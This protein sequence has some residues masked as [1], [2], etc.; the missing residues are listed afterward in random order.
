MEVSTEQGLEERRAELH[1]AM[2]AVIDQFIEERYAVCPGVPFETVRRTYCA[3]AHG[4]KCEEFK[5][6]QAA[7]T[8]A[9][10]LARKQQSEIPA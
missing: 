4:C 10:N 5:I 8:F 7:I 1:A 3:R 9:E 6:I 2:D